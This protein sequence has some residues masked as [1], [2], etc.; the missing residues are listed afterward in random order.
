MS[1]PTPVLITKRGWSEVEVPWSAGSSFFTVIIEPM[2]VRGVRVGA[3]AAND[4]AHF[5]AL[6]Q[7]AED[8]AINAFVFDTKQDGGRVLYDTNVDDAHEIGAVDVWYDPSVRLAQTHD[9]GL[10]AITRIVVFE[11]AFRTAAYPDEKLAG[12]WVDPRAQDA[13]SYNIDLAIEACELG[14]DEIQFDYVRFPP[15]KTAQVSGQLDL[16]QAER[17][18][19]IEGFLAEAHESLEPMGCVVSAAVLAIVVSVPNDQ[20]LGQ[21]P[22]ELSRHVEALSPMVYPSHY[23][24]G[25]LGFT[26]PNDHPYEVTANAIDDAIPRLEPGTRLRPWLQAFWWTNSQ[27]RESIQA[28]EDR[29]VGW[30][31]W[32]VRSNFD[33]AALPGPDE[34]SG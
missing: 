6:L 28:A 2:K 7:L 3:G 18:S 33:R 24:D 17:V 31:L 21:T 23:G 14:F 1:S 9:H 8:T 27:I 16:T 5:E 13:W 12:P 11:D 29:D 19:A 15:G 34:V 4:D 25:W 26:D 22:E 32:N 10:Y 30:I 20:G